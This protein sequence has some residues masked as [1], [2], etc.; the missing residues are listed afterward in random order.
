M[1]ASRVLVVEDEA[2]VATD[3]AGTLRGLGCLV[4]AVAASGEAA[5]EA[6]EAM[7]PD[8]VLMDI[9]LKGDI[10]GVKAAREIGD[11]FGIPVVYLTAHA[12]EQTLRRAKVT[13]PFGYI[14]KPFD[15]RD[16][17]VA[18]EIALHRHRTQTTL[19]RLAVV[20][21]L[22]GLYNRRGFTS[23]VS[24]HVKLGRRTGMGFWLILID[25]DRLKRINDTF[26]H[27]EGD[28]ALVMTADILKKTFRESDVVARLGG[29]EFAVL[30]IDAADDSAESMTGRLR[31][32]LEEHNRQVVALYDL[33]FSVGLARFDPTL[34][35]SIEPVMLMAD[36]DL[37]RN[38]NNR[39][40][41]NEP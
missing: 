6:A 36:E 7:R 14:L 18:I 19:R 30:A 3:I 16:L 23:L 15:E 31:E 34:S 21:E 25:V 38:K 1:T 35:S 9:R 32:N 22:T 12:D 29:D 20:D 41:P 37:Y 11:R 4:T 13:Q 28:R 2:I 10:D 40:G 27:Q 8:L 33:S 24:Q 39:E 17:Y 26:G 5:I